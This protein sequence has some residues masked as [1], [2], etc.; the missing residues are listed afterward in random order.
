MSKTPVEGSAE[1]GTCAQWRNQSRSGSAPVPCH[2]QLLSCVSSVFCILLRLREIIVHRQDRLM[3]KDKTLQLKRREEKKHTFWP[4]IKYILSSCSEGGG[5]G[6]VLTIQTMNTMKSRRNTGEISL[7]RRLWWE[8]RIG[9]NM[10]TSRTHAESPAP[11]HASAIM[12]EDPNWEWDRLSSPLKYL[13][14]YFAVS[15]RVADLHKSS[16]T[17]EEVRTVCDS[18]KLGNAVNILEESSSESSTI[19]LLS[20]MA[21]AIKSL[22]AA[23]KLLCSKLNQQQ[24]RIKVIII[25]AAHV[26]VYIIATGVVFFLSLLVLSCFMSARWTCCV[27]LRA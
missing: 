2:G 25:E 11:A 12:S 8:A 15:T 16:F 21:V 6:W 7:R 27:P 4:S 24:Q 10:H 9:T 14:V 23:W 18:W 3:G 1:P 5:S 17:W 19:K 26:A 22:W 20:V 13:S